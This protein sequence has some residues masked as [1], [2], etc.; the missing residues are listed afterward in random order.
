MSV[1]AGDGKLKPT[2]YMT[3]NNVNTGL[4]CLIL[5]YELVTRAGN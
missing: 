2:K 5:A 1:S 4:A 3:L